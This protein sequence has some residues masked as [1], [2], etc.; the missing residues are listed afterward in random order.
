MSTEGFDLDNDHI[1]GEH[2]ND[3][4]HRYA[5]EY[6]LEKHIHF[7]CIVSSADDEG[8]AGWMLTVEHKLDLLLANST[9]HAR[10]LV[11]ATGLTS[12]PFMQKG[13]SVKWSKILLGHSMRICLYWCSSRLGDSRIWSRTMLDDAKPSYSIQNNTRVLIADKTNHL[14]ESMYLG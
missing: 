4:L 7:D 10:R 8:E 12:E 9:V 3:Y 2:V 14:A 5:K 1:P 6:D 13:S 11:M